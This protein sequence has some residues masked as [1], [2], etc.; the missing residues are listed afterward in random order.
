[1]YGSTDGV[2]GSLL[3]VLSQ[4]KIHLLMPHSALSWHFS[5]V[6]NRTS[7]SLQDRATECHN[8]LTELYTN[9]RCKIKNICPDLIQF[10]NLTKNYKYF[11]WNELWW[12]S[13]LKKRKPWRQTCSK[14]STTKEV[15]KFRSS[16]KAE[17]AQTFENRLF[18]VF[19]F[20]FG[21]LILLTR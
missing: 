9:N 17:Y 2:T 19:P 3:E 18:F 12:K 6:R 11:K 5:I 7:L 1:M 14:T 16:L 21:K 8:F 15:Q 10:S 4:L 13:L 20:T